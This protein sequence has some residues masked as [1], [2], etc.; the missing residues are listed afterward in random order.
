MERKEYVG[1]YAEDNGEYTMPDVELVESEKTVY[2]KEMEKYLQEL[3]ATQKCDAAERARVN[4]QKCNIIGSDG[5][6][7]EKYRCDKI[8]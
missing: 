8:F 4:L 3:M 6:F 7:T 2:I 5:E 1:L